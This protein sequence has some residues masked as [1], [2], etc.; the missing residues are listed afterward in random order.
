MHS[1]SILHVPHNGDRTRI[2]WTHLKFNPIGL[3]NLRLHQ[4]TFPR[5]PNFYEANRARFDAA[6]LAWFAAGMHKDGNHH[7]DPQSFHAL[8]EALQKDTKDTSVS[9]LERKELLQRVQDLTFDMATLWDRALGGTTMIL[10]CTGTTVPGAPLRPEFLKAH[11]YLPPAFVD[12]NPQLRE[13][14]MGLVQLFIETIALKTAR[15]WPRRAQVS[16]GY[17]LTQPGYAQ[18]N[19]PMTSFPEPEL[20]SS[21]Y[22]FLG[23]PTTI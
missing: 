11:V 10:H 12:H 16:F 1:S 18:A 6:D 8:A 14:I 19:Q 23:Q 9:R 15:D 7:H 3:Y 4:G 22:K 5:L 20:N 13:P 17:R 21:Y 2:A